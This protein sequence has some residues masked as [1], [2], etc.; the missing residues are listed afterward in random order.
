MENETAAVV[1]HGIFDTKGCGYNKNAGYGN[2]W[3]SVCLTVSSSAKKGLEGWNYTGRKVR[4]G[5]CPHHD[6]RSGCRLRTRMAAFQHR[7][8]SSYTNRSM[9][10]YVVHDIE[11]SKRY[12]KK[13][14]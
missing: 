2:Y 7:Y 13:S 14:T 1:Y 8:L 10:T 3:P 5:G 4:F 9:I 11:P 6:C 12:L